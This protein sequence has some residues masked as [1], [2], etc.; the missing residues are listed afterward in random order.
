[1]P[2]GFDGGKATTDLTSGFTGYAAIPAKVGKDKERSKELLRVINYFAA[3]FGSEEW[4][5]M[6]YGIEGIHHTVQPDGSRVKTDLGIQEIG[7]LNNLCGPLTTYYWPIPGDAAEAQQATKDILA[8]GIDNPTLGLYSPTAS[9]KGAELN[10]LRIDRVD[11]MV[12][13]RDPL[14]ALD[15]FVKDW[16]A[17]VAT[18]SVRSTSKPSKHKD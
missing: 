7:D 10:Q 5:F 9:A 12:T 2:P 18:R 6:N 14:S 15:T 3:P 8:L 1:M 17:V 16:R 13:G 11:A 4:A